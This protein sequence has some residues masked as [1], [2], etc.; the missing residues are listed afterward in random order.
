MAYGTSYEQVFVGAFW[1][2]K[3]TTGPKMV[4]NIQGSMV[5]VCTWSRVDGAL[6][7]IACPSGD[8]PEDETLHNMAI[9]VL[10]RAGVSRKKLKVKRV[11]EEQFDKSGLRF[12]ESA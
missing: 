8:W 4:W 10:R 6:V 1:P 7:V 12:F 5:A 3:S 9:E 11:A 2:R